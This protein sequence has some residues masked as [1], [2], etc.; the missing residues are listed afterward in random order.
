MGADT[1]MVVVLEDN[2]PIAK[3]IELVLA[4]AGCFQLVGPFP[5]FVGSEAFLAAADA[6]I[7]DLALDDLEGAALFDA[8]RDA[9]RPQTVIVVHSGQ[10]DPEQTAW[11]PP[12]VDFV[13]KG[14]TADLVGL[15]RQRLG[16]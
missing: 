10:F 15:L 11:L 14:H 5:A 2:L 16:L 4:R 9:V 1:P 7:L 6:V 12:D 3:L 8:V 13:E